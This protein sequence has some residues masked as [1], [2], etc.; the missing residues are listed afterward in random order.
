MHG[1]AV[2]FGVGDGDGLA[3]EEGIHGI[4][5]VVIGGLGIVEGVGLVVHGA[6]VDEG[7][8]FVDDEGVGRGFHA[9]EVAD[10]AAAV[11]DPSGG[12]D[13]AVGPFLAGLL[14]G[15]MAGVIG[16]DGVHEEPDDAFSG[17]VFLQGLG[18]ALVLIVAEGTVRIV[19]L[20]DDN[21]TFVIGKFDG[22][23][24]NIGAGEIRCGL[25]DFDGKR[26]SGKGQS[27]KEGECG[28][29]VIDCYFVS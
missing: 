22:F 26:A 14:G 11:I 17:E 5:D 18:G 2:G 6:V 12:V 7:A 27:D 15:A 23:T 25:A 16:V 10:G 20:D 8:V 9:V 24:V 1:A 21:F 13:A 29:H 4:A 19:R 28:F 3:G